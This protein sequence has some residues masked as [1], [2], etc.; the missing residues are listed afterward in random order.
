MVVVIHVDDMIISGE[1]NTVKKSKKYLKMNYTINDL[2]EL[3]VHLGVK[4]NWINNKIGDNYLFSS[5]D[6]YSK[7]IVNF[8]ESEFERT[9]E[10]YTPVYANEFLSR[11]FIIKINQ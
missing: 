4:Y 7:E 6:E 1:D 8:Y 3:D 9:K 5:M 11:K 2:G 10:Y